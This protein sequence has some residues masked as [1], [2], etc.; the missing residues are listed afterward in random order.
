MT[1]VDG[2]LPPPF[3]FQPRRGKLDWRSL[4]KLDLE[5]VA[6]EVDIDSLERHL[7]GVA[8]AD[9][10]KEDLHWF[11]DGDFLQLFR[12]LQLVCEYLLYVQETL[13][14]RNVVLEGE[15]EGAHAQLR[16][17][18]EYIGVLESQLA[19]AAT[20]RR[21]G[22][23]GLA[24]QAAPNKCLVCHKVFSTDAYLQAHI[25]RRHPGHSQPAVHRMGMV[26]IVWR[27]R[28]C[29]RGAVHRMEK[30]GLCVVCDGNRHILTILPILVI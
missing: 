10:T 5:R 21:M 28:L 27:S 14:K 29:R 26:C 3:A 17:Q 30:G 16:D 8:F 15:L 25:T 11:S 2:L 20:H 6:R 1:T 7:Q 13:H 22:G 9:V 4:S 18:A 19:A 24:V 23:S 12:M